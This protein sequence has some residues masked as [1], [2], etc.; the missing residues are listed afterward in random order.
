MLGWE[1]QETL[2]RDSWFN[3]PHRA[4]IVSCLVNTSKVTH[5]DVN[6][7]QTSLTSTAHCKLHEPIGHSS[8][9]ILQYQALHIHSI[10]VT[11]IV[12]VS[13]AF[14]VNPTQSVSCQWLTVIIDLSELNEKLK[15]SEDSART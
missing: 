2:A 10:Q 15:I 7:T 5:P 14:I 1:R 9:S 13:T 12:F 8:Y 11:Y 6:L 3:V 4:H